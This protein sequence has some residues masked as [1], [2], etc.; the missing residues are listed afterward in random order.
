MKIRLA[1]FA[2]LLLLG[3]EPAVAK[4]SCDNAVSQNEM[5]QCAE[6]DF[7][8]AD[9]ELNGIYKKQMDSLDDESKALLRASQ[10]LWVQFRDAECKYV[11]AANEGGSIYPLVQFGCMTKLTKLRIPQLREGQN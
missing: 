1:A 11:N 9:M 2:V 10:R 6:D 3:S 8:R 5:N 4:N 7:K